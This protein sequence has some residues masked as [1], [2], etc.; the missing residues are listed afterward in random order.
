[1]YISH[2]QKGE[3]AKA[4]SNL[5]RAEAQH[6]RVVSLIKERKAE[7]AVLVS[8][9]QK[10]G[11]W[12]GVDELIALQSRLRALDKAIED[13]KG[14]ETESLERVESARRYLYQLY[15]RLERLRQ[16][17]AWPTKDDPIHLTRLRMQ[18]EA[19]AGAD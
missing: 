8:D 3:L 19:I 16:E 7:R 11:S 18:I 12:E 10:Q 17:A 1:M 14:T 9:I 6:G 2:R 13:M 5:E 15:V 4:E